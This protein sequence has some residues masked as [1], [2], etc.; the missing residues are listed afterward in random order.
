M[1]RP[2][3][4]ADPKP[5]WTSSSFLVYTGGL[6]VLLGA[7]VGLAYLASQYHGH[8]TQVAWTLLF[9][10]VV[11]GIAHALR[12]GDRWLAAGIFAFVS[13]LVWGTLVYFTMRWIGWH[14]FSPGLY[15]YGSV[16]SEWSWSRMLFWILV[17]AAASG[18]RMHFKFPFI[19]LISAVVFWLFV[20]DLL[21]SG[22]G[23]WFAIVSLLTGLLYLMVGNVIDKPS[24]F[25]L[26]LISGALIGG[27]FL[28]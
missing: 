18:N 25:W 2:R 26:H 22:H 12:A 1:M 28:Y 8:G 27:V 9:F 23:T 20:S 10:V 24:A 5:I 4:R 13:V 7:S 16:F 21:T 19:R 14:P 6:T 15:S 17:L 11:A 3:V